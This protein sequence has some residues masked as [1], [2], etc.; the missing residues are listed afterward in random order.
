MNGDYSQD[1]IKCVE[2]VLSTRLSAETSERRSEY[3]EPTAC[4]PEAVATEQLSSTPESPSPSLSSSEYRIEDGPILSKE[5]VGPAPIPCRKYKPKTVEELIRNTKYPRK[6]KTM[7][8]PNGMNM[9]P[10]PGAPYAPGGGIFP[11]A[12]HHNDVQHIWK[13]VEELSGALQANRQQY[14]ELQ[15]SITR[16]QVRK[17]KHSLD[18]QEEEEERDDDDEERHIQSLVWSLTF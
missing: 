16:G 7:A 1:S 15:E 13:L 9:N 12:G 8:A 18:E 4:F 11:N 6:P 14:E 2:T 10:G 3:I 17:P 5:T